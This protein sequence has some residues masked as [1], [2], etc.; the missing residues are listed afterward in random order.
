MGCSR[1]TLVFLAIL[2]AISATVQAEVPLIGELGDER[3]TLIYD[4]MDGNLSLDAAGRKITTLEILSDGAVFLGIKP[5]VLTESFDVYQ[6]KKLFKMDAK[7]FG[8]LDFG[9]AVLKDL[10]GPVLARDL[11]VEGSF[12]PEGDL[13]V[14][15]LMLVPEPSGCF[16]AATLGVG[17]SVMRRAMHRSKRK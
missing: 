11:T 14:V 16:L 6:P 10:P 13:G 5:E 9:P 15:D 8:D 12:H 4:P 3:V 2:L 7:G 1:F 17:F